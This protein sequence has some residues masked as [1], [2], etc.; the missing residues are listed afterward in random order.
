MKKMFIVVVLF[1]AIAGAESC[2]TTVVARPADPVVV[3]PPQP[4]PDYIWVGGEWIIVGGKYQ[5]RQGYWAA[6][7]GRRVWVSGH[8]VSRGKGYYWVHGHWR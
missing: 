6:P 4:R 3:R 8:W 7:R 2:R 1:I 5:Y